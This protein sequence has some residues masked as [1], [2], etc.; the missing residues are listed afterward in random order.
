MMVALAV[1]MAVSSVCF[2]LFRQYVSRYRLQTAVSSSTSTVQLALN[3]MLHEI[4]MAGYPTTALMGSAGA[5]GFT[6]AN[7]ASITFETAL[8]PSQTTVDQVTYSLDEDAL[9]RTVAVKGGGSTSTTTLARGVTALQFTYL[10]QNNQPTTTAAQVCGVLVTMA[11]KAQI[12]QAAGQSA[13]VPMQGTA[14]ARNI[15]H[16]NPGS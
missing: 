5:A 2:A 16:L 1:L 8:D 13:T 11:V 3:Q 12:S 7:P 4:R 15:C 10:D 14:F 9:V 6:V